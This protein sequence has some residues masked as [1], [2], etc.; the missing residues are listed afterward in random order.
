M[1]A[2]W[3]WLR[4]REFDEDD[5]R[6]S[7]TASARTDA[8]ELRPTTS[9]CAGRS[10]GGERGRDCSFSETEALGRDVLLAVDLERHAVARFDVLLRLHG[11]LRQRIEAR[12]LRGRER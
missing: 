3:L 10:D 11:L 5:F 9:G 7:A 1:L 4:P 8:R 2:S 12:L 6:L